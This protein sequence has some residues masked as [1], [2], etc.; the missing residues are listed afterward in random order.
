MVIHVTNKVQLRL[1][2]T[3]DEVAE[4]L[5]IGRSAVY[6]SIRRGDL[7]ALRFGRRI[8]VPREALLRLLGEED[9]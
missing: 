6:E 7:P 5:G 9:K 1:T 4:I 2:L 8:V 3:A